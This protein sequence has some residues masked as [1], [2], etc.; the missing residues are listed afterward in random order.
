MNRAY[1]GPVRPGEKICTPRM[2]EPMKV[3][4]LAF[5]ALGA[6]PSPPNA[7]RS[8]LAL[9]GRWERHVHGKILDLIQ[10]PSSLHP[11]GYY[12]L[13]REFLLPKLSLQE[14]VYVHFEGITYFGRVAVNGVELG[15]MGP[16]VPYEFEFTPEAKEGTN[17]IEVA[18][19]DLVPGPDGAGK[20]ELA[21]GVNPGWE[22]YGGIIRDV[23]VE[24]RPSAFI[25][26][27]RFGYELSGDYSRAECRAQVY[28]SSREAGSGEVEVVLQHGA[29][30][31]ARG[32]K[33]TALRAGENEVEVIFRLND[34]AL[35]SPQSPQLYELQAR[36]KSGGREDRWGCRTGFR[37][38]KTAG[39]EFR[40][41][42][43]RLVLNGVCRHDMWKEQGFTL[44]RAQ[45]EQDMRMIK[46]LGCNFV[47]LVHYPHDRHIVELADE[48]GLLVSEEPGYWG[49]DFQ[50]MA[51]SE[52]ELGYRI[53]EK[54]I[55]RD[56]N[57]PSVLA[58]LLSNECT[59]TVEV[60]KEGKEWCNKLD[61]IHRLVS[62]A[63]SMSDEKAKPIFEASGMDFFD[64]HPYVPDPRDY[65]KVAA[66]YDDSRPLTF[67]EWGWE[68]VGEQDIFPERHS[69]LI[70]NLIE[71][72]KLAGTSFWSWQD[73]RQYSRIDWPTAS[74]I[75]MSGV[76]NE[77]REVRPDWYLELSRLFEGRPE[78]EQPAI[79]RPTL[80]PMQWAPASP[81]STFLT[82]N[83]QALVGSAEGE[84]SWTWL[85]AEL[86]EF[87]AKTSMAKNQWKRTGEKFRLWQRAELQ[88]A[89]IP[90]HAPAIG[91]YVRP[92]LLTP[93]VSNV[94]IPIN[95][96]CIR[97]HILGQVTFPSGFP[98]E[99]RYGETAATYTLSYAGGRSQVLPVR[100]G[101][102]AAQANRIHE[103]TRINPIATAAPRAV[104]FVK[105]VVR[106][107]YQVLLWTVPVGKERLASLN[108]TLQAHQQA[109]A[110]FAITAERAAK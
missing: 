28:V 83:L 103:A 37:E 99:G 22:A 102:E 62:A 48:V 43:K 65:A 52:I 53:L 12:R 50:T 88:V 61:P 24:L 101:I 3:D 13:R 49:M 74:G 105:D 70:L 85:E 39:R 55:Q 69:D 66:A 60:L 29:A 63:N 59:L 106:E 92:L 17:Q 16:Y 67:T 71:S 38:V 14:R 36:L 82:V 4:S 6:V 35:W 84:K 89:G 96:E 51:R 95:L 73:M 109:L 44:T 79:A 104:D 90:F 100:N 46:A 32:E 42:G 10:V 87:W 72:G 31:V 68:S 9:G 15:T 91:S 75:L 93:E 26:N 27:V 25:G 33:T 8:R 77:A 5:P 19:T 2:F 98:I 23:Y 20:D 18:I 30:E 7:S 40:L 21:L 94:T 97:L 34:V 64:Q 86:A 47:R 80:V 54:T 1:A 76:V 58:W 108:C 11:L 41:N 81:R 45:Q 56:W 110:I 78:E 107:Q 57:S